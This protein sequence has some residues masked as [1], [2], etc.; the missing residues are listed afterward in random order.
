MLTRRELMKLGILA[1]GGSLVSAQC[2]AFGFLGGGL[3]SSPPLRRFPDD[4]LLTIPSRLNDALTKP[5]EAKPLPKEHGSDAPVEERSSPRE[6]LGLDELEFLHEFHPDLPESPIWGYNGQFPGPTIHA[7]TGHPIRLRVRNELPTPTDFGVPK[8]VVHLHGGH[9]A[10]A[11]DG[12]PTDWFAQGDSKDYIYPN[13]PAGNDPRETP[14]TLWYHDHVIDFTAE[15]VYRGLLG[16]YLVFD[17]TDSG[18]ET[19][20]RGLRLPSGPWD[21]PLVL[22]DKQFS[23][24]TGRLVYDPFDHDGFL[25]DRVAV[26]GRIQP[27]APIPR[28]K[29]RFRLLNASNARFYELFLRRAGTGRPL[30]EPFVQ[31]ASDGGLLPH[32]LPRT[33]LLLTNGERIEVVI[34][35]SRFREGEEVFLENRLLQSDGRGPNRPTP[36]G[37]PGDELLKFK[38]GAAP[39][40][41]DPSRV[42]PTLTSLPDLPQALDDLPREDLVFDRKSGAW[43]I[44]KR[45]FDP[46]RP[47]ITTPL[48]SGAIW[49]LRNDS[50]RWWH[51]I[52]LHLEFFR[53]LSRNG[54]LPPRHER[55]KKDTV[56]LGPRD[57]VEIFV[58]FR[59]FPG[60]YVLHCHNL[61]HEDM[62]MM[63]RYDVV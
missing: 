38:I 33:S 45:F 28:R 41:G 55:G 6:T 59:D 39:R 12:Y 16:L 46:D 2:K 61:E 22:T 8:T 42:P 3:P 44:N 5:G 49:R 4:W 20:S 19:D 32:P 1:S 10:S 17:E 58:Q 43:V 30:D 15:N 60:K 35:F 57:E 9:Q 34:D 36:K 54:K 24:E 31:I 47:L 51:P 40:G 23:P 63:A 7:Q 37:E 11:H 21:I 50:S 56:L 29:V 26:N 25:G 27:T 52:H 48:G 53:I 13:L 18:D 62:F 14:S